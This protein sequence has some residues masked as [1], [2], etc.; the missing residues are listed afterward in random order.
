MHNVSTIIIMVEEAQKCTVKRL[1]KYNKKQEYNSKKI[2][3]C[4]HGKHKC[5]ILSSILQT[6]LTFWKIWPV[7]FELYPEFLAQ[8]TKIVLMVSGQM[9][10]VLFTL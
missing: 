2:K 8:N 9:Q 5:C 1:T 10:R 6:K 3:W 7:D 4:V